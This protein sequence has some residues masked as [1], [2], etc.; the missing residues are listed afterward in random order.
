MKRLVTPL[1]RKDL[2]R[3]KAGDEVAVSGWVYTARD[4][5]HRRFLAAI[6][7]QRSLPFDPAG[8]LVYYTGPTPTPPGRAI[9]SCGPTTSSRMDPFT[10]ALLERGVAATMGKGRRGPEV[11]EA[12]REYGAVYLLT[13][14]GCG[15]YL[16]TFVRERRVIA[17]PDL[18]TE[19]VA[20]LLMRDFPAIVGIDAR[21]RDFYERRR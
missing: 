18:G 15:A 12:C 20:V 13:Y 21:G 17:Y 3:L 7:A 6:A 5:A 8:A 9:G 10:P 2:L 16:S 1:A 4:A 11:R 14:G 19:A